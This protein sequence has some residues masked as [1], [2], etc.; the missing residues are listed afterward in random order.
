MR[1]LVLAALVLAACGAPARE[2]DITGRV[3]RITE[4]AEGRLVML[5]EDRPGEHVGNKVAV[6]V[7][8]NTRI[9]RE[10]P[11]G[12]LDAAIGDLGTAAVVS[13]WMDGPILMSYPDQGKAEAVLIRAGVPPL[14]PLPSRSP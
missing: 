8:R 5:V 6:T 3:T 12:R 4:P 10:S 1:M 11:N 7:D 14:P 9:F 2:P 13:V